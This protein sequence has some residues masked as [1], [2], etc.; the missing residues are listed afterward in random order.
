MS[1]GMATES[2]SPSAPLPTSVYLSYGIGSMGTGLFSAVP[3]LLLLYFMTEILGVPAGLAGLAVFIPKI[4]DVITDPIMGTISDRTRSRWGRRRPYLLA[5]A[6]TLPLFF[7]LL[8]SVPAFQKPATSFAYVTVVFML[9]ATA[10]TLFQVPYI[11]MPAE[12]TQD[13]HERTTLM[14]YRMVFMTAGILVA[15]GAAPMIIQA[16]GGGRLGYA[17]MSVTLAVIC[18][19]V[20]LAAFFGTARAP[21]LERAEAA[22]PWREQVRIAFQNRPF[23]ILLVGYFPQQVAVGSIL[24]TLPFYVKYILGG[25]ESIVT[26]LF[27]CLVLPAIV[28]MPV[29]VR[30]S[31]R[32]G[33]LAGFLISSALFALMGLSLLT[34]APGRL[35]LLYLQVVIM[36]AAYAGIQLFPFSML[37]DTIQLD[38]V[39][40]GLRREGIFTGVW[41][42]AEKTGMAVGALVS[43]SILAWSGFVETV[44][45]QQAVQP[46]AALKGILVAA[47]AAPVCMLALSLPIIW[48]YDLSE[49]RLNQLASGPR[50][51]AEAKIQGRTQ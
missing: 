1:R 6:L 5:G 7:C 27:V 34:A 8:F 36:G 41:T 44:A 35:P 16:A 48:R 42:A 18:L 37:P 12:M 50:P 17:L 49:A 2:G 51:G 33:K 40:S 24:A 11:A 29:W 10:Y 39:Q 19:M 31:R 47:S 43:G 45:G 14:S 32:T 3:G 38:H 46:A 13:Y 22:V 21:F 20:M 23:I 15:G 9:C 26:L 4:W 30:I 28:T 25:T